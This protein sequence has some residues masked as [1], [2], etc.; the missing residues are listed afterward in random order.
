M[1][2][3]RRC[4]R[5]MAEPEF[6]LFQ[7]EKV[8]IKS[9]DPLVLKVE[10]LEA[11]RLKDY[12]GL[13]QEDC[14]REM[15]VSRPTF[16]RILSHARYQV[17]QALIQGKPLQ[18]GGGDYCLG[19]GQC[20]RHGRTLLP[21]EGCTDFSTIKNINDRR[22]DA[23]NNI[24]ICSSGEKETSL[25]DDRFGRC[26]FFVVFNPEVKTYTAI[27]N[28][29]SD[30]ARGA[31]TGSA[32]KLIQAGAG[33]VIANRIGPKAFSALQSA[34]IKV[35]SGASGLTIHEALQQYEAGKL[36]ELHGPNN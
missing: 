11:L 31:G 29:G 27:P 34:G 26:A 10:E 2:R 35:F 7:P 30:A 19:Q 32:Q 18:I 22:E 3:K 17:S 23:M 5:V 1:P 4:R 9:G 33:I 24:I 15:Q 14:A 28:T 6:S 16:Q 20:R 36:Q 13:E 21:G 25:V 12:L 8:G